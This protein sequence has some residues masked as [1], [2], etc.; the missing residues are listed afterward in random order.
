MKSTIFVSIIYINIIYIYIYIYI[1]AKIII[2]N[3][4]YRIPYT[5]VVYVLRDI[6][7]IRNV[8]GERPFIR[9]YFEYILD[10]RYTVII[11][12]LH[13]YLPV[14]I[15]KREKERRWAKNLVNMEYGT[16]STRY[17]NASQT[18]ALTNPG[19]KCTALSVRY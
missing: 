13:V 5:G 9:I 1:Y 18:C 16:P 15:T 11:I 8:T 3:D 19:K 7:D 14:F 2:M 4:R 17:S 12:K 6:I 10:Y